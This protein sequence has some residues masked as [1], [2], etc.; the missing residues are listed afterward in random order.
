MNESDITNMRIR[1]PVSLHQ[2]IQH[3]AKRDRRSMQS[4]ILNALEK[5]F[6]KNVDEKSSMHEK[7]PDADT[8]EAP[9]HN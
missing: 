8:S 9:V 5:V 3:E 1:M 4:L 2:A 7:A 6:Q